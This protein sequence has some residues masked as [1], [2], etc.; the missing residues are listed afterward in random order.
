[1]GR[2]IVGGTAGACAVPD[3]ACAC[4]RAAMAWGETRRGV[5]DAEDDAGAV[6]AGAAGRADLPSG[7]AAAASVGT[8]SRRLATTPATAI[9]RV[10]HLP[11]QLNTCLPPLARVHPSLDAGPG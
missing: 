11:V 9:P 5:A 7:E 4:L 10:L 3:T 1:R 6:A 2:L 8:S